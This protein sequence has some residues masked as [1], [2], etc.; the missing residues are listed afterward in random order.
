MFVWPLQHH[1]I[2]RG[3]IQMENYVCTLQCPSLLCTNTGSTGI[4]CIFAACSLI[5]MY[6]CKYHRRLLVPPGV[7]CICRTSDH[8]CAAILATY[9]VI[10]SVFRLHMM[11]VRPLCM[12]VYRSQ[13]VCDTQTAVD[14]S[15]KNVSCKKCAERGWTMNERARNHGCS[16]TTWCMYYV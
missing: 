12:Y 11:Y 5:S 8:L 6:I 1:G 13:S 14:R 7:P 15:I 10:C 3:I 2:R 4:F 16:V 9:L